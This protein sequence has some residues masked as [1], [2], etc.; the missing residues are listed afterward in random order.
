M[1]LTTD[2]LHSRSLTL[3][4]SEWLTVINAFD[5]FHAVLTDDLDLYD[6]LIKEF[7]DSFNANFV[8]E[9]GDRIAYGKSTVVA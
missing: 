5:V 7:K 9:L 1:A 2:H 6:E 4:M 3:T 8:K